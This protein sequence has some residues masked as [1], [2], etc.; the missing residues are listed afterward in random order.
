MGGKNNIFSYLKWRGDLS[1]EADGFNEVDS[2][3]FSVIA[4]LD[5]AKAEKIHTITPGLAPSLRDVSLAVDGKENNRLALIK[6]EEIVGALHLAAQT[7]RFSEVKILGY[8][9]HNDEETTMQFAAVTFLLPNGEIYVA[10][11]GTDDTLLGWKEDLI[12]SY[13]PYVASQ[14]EAL[15]YLKFI[16][17]QI[18]NKAIYTGGHSKGG[19]LAVYAAVKAPEEIKKRLKGVYNNDGPGFQ[20][21]FLQTEEYKLVSPLIHTFIPES[22][23]VGM[24]LEHEESY[25]VISSSAKAFLQHAPLSWEVM[26]KS[27]VYLESRSQFGRY[28]DNVL[29]NW[30][31]TCTNEEKEEFVEAL[32]NILASGRARTLW[33]LTEGDFLHHWRSILKTYSGLDKEKKDL[34]NDLLKRLMGEI[35]KEAIRDNKILRK[36]DE[37]F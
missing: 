10:Y 9:C 29:R 26:G 23:I 25:Q 20:E 12:M 24:L 16:S 2:L 19:N 15:E 36:I 18:P 3:I 21:E 37:T 30:L 5:L 7:K 27:F 1:F 6:V 11:R 13:A 33:E 14:Q 8:I 35:K 22:S 28:T 4:Y 17:E 34:L 31:K 32:F